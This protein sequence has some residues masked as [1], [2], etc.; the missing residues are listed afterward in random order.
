MSRARDNR[1]KTT[2]NQI[3]E[4]VF[5]LHFL[6]RNYGVGICRDYQ[7]KTDMQNISNQFRDYYRFMYQI[8]RNL[9]NK[10]QFKELFIRLDFN[11]FYQNNAVGSQGA[12]SVTR[13][14]I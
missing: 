9:A 11:N 8:V 12:I 6:V 13:N 4:F 5:K 3:F 7:A 14:I 10:G 1:L 2:M